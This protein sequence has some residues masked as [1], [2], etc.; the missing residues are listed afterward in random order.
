MNARDRR[1]LR[2]GAAASALVVLAAIALPL[3]RRVAE[4]EALI[5]ARTTEL[6]RLRG[7]IAD[8][9][10]VPAALSL[11]QT[12]NAQLTQRP[13]RSETFATA[14]GVLQTLLQQY[15]DESQLTVA[16][17]DAAGA[18]DST[19]NGAAALPATLVATGDLYG[20]RDLLSR[21]ERGAVLLEVRELTVQALPGQLGA[22][23]HERL[24]VTVV[25]RAP[26]M[27]E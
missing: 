5:D 18:A 14:A 23:G 19:S 17:L 26:V 10:S 22:S 20:V 16:Q 25:L 4:R 9:G 21:L 1:A 2:W 15:A 24:Q 12:R 6:A 11:R 3:A 13:I 8:S 27:V 7:V